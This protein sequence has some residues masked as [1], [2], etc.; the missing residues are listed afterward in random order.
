[1]IW[2]KNFAKLAEDELAEVY[3]ARNDKGLLSFWGESGVSLAEFKNLA[4]SA[5]K[6]RFAVFDEDD[7]FGVI[8]FG[9]ISAQG[10]ELSFYKNPQ[11]PRVGNI[12][13]KEAVRYAS[14]NLGLKFL[15][16]SVAK[17]NRKARS[18]LTRSGFVETGGAERISMKK[19]ITKV[20]NEKQI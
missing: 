15:T 20:E 5:D 17:N 11:I 2:L 19:F 16:A 14:Q 9:D 13:I 7:F 18:L 6:T 12:L 8:E 1:M 4:K 3:A 10:A